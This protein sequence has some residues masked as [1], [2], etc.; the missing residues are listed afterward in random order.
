MNNPSSGLPSLH[1]LPAPLNHFVGRERELEEVQKL[2]AAHR[3][4]ILTGPS[5]CGKTRLAVEAG[6]AL[7]KA[8]PAGVWLVDFSLIDDPQQVIPILASTLNVIAE[9]RQLI[10]RLGESQW[11]LS[12]R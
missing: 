12:G 10:E 5:G 9:G 4:V 2:N 7:L 1:N 8:Y 6:R 11:Q 3:L